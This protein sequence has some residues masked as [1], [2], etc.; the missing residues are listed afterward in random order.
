MTADGKPRHPAYKGLSE[1][2]DNAAIFRVDPS[3]DP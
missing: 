2:Q 3:V 1:M